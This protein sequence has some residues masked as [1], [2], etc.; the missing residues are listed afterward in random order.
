MNK[1]VATN[2]TPGV[3]NSCFRISPMVGERPAEGRPDD[4][5]RM[6]TVRVCAVCGESRDTWQMIQVGREY[7]LVLCIVWIKMV[8][9]LTHWTKTLSFPAR[10]SPN[11]QSK[12]N[13]MNLHPSSPTVTPTPSNN[14]LSP[15]CTKN[16]EINNMKNNNS[17]LS[18]VSCSWC[19]DLESQRL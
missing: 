10:I 5:M 15:P 14:S 2:P 9:S 6:K 12:E 4:W 19:N 13:V 18:E 3:S 1:Y 8:R 11:K 17:S 7:F 16:N